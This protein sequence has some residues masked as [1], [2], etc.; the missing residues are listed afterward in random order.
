MCLQISIV[1]VLT[2]CAWGCRN[3]SFVG[4]GAFEE[5]GWN[6]VTGQQDGKKETGGSTTYDTEEWTVVLAL[7]GEET[8]MDAHARRR[9]VVQNKEG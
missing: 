6:I 2:K 3:R 7:R 9:R 5:N 8:M 4:T 1:R